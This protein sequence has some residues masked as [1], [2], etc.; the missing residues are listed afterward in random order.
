M[1]SDRQG[2]IHTYL[3][4]SVTDRCNLRCRYCMPPGGIERVDRERILHPEEIGRIVQLFAELGVRKIRL[5]GGEPLI[6]GGLGVILGYLTSVQPH[7]NLAL[8]TNGLL[9]EKWLHR[10]TA[11]GVRFINVSL[12]TLREERYAGITGFQGWRS[13][14]NGVAAALKHPKIE[15][16]KLNVVIQRGVNDDEVRDFARLT[17]RYPLDVRFIEIMPV[18][19][20]DWNENEL[21]TGEEIL[22]KLP[23]L[24]I[25]SLRIGTSDGPAR[26]YRYPD[27]PGR[28]GFI[29][30]LSCPVCSQ[31][32][33][34]RLTAQGVLLRCLFDSEGLDLRS[35]V[36]TGLASDEIKNKITEFLQGKR[37]AGIQSGT[38]NRASYYSPCLAVVGG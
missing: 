37:D 33:R 28:I 3:R 16:V 35:A 8:T 22:S 30:S 17:L 13:V 27:A 34:L 7:V 21:V 2:R 12:D 14:W 23:E 20:I 10:L 18:R 24:E 15:K 6:R 4:V 19:R 1:L 11:G 32:N 9:L 36:R 25:E 38:S 29:S 31:C 5:T 26:M